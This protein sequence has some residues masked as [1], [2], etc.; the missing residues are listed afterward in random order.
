MAIQITTEILTGTASKVRSINQ[1][2]D[3]DLAQ[4]NSKMQA[5]ES[6]WSSDAASDIRSAMNALK[7]RFEEYKSTVET[8]AKFLDTTATSYEAT[9]TAI[10]TNAGAFK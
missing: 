8:Y 9:E 4:I 6:T 10:Q 5:L 1:L 7:P 2:L 3:D